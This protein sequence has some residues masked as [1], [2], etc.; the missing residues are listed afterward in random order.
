MHLTRWCIAILVRMK[1][2]Q[3]GLSSRLIRK[4]AT[5]KKCQKR[6]I[7]STYKNVFKVLSWFFHINSLYFNGFS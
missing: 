7:S 3:T 4:K 6:Q 5:G 2:M 1:R